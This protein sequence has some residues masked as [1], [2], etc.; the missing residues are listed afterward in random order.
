MGG[1][2]LAVDRPGQITLSRDDEVDLL[3]A[4]GQA[5]TAFALDRSDGLPLNPPR[6]I[7]GE[8]VGL[9]AGG[10][11]EGV[12]PLLQGALGK[13]GGPLRAQVGL[14][15]AR[16]V[17]ARVVVGIGEDGGREGDARVGLLEQLA[18][19]LLRGGLPA[20]A[21]VGLAN[22]ALGVG[23]VVGGPVVVVEVGPSGQVMPKRSTP[24]RTLSTSF[25]KAYSG[26]WTPIT[27]R[28][29]LA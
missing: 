8:G 13:A 4:V 27:C 21:D 2:G 3:T 17:R 20:L 5:Q 29:Y 25:S 28:P 12:L 16:A 19:V 18:D 1:A 6:A 26:E 22:V 11:G 15:G 24:P 9:E 10:E 7:Q 23:Q 14:G